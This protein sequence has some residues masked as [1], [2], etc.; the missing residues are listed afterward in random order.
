VRSDSPVTVVYAGRR[1][2]EPAATDG[3]VLLDDWG[4]LPRQLAEVLEGAGQLVILDPLSFPFESLPSRYWDIPMV[5]ELPADL[6]PGRL[7]ALL[8]SIA[9]SRLGF[10]DVLI[11][12][13]DRFGELARQY[14]LPQ[15]MR[16]D[17]DGSPGPATLAELIDQAV[18]HQMTLAQMRGRSA[19]RRDSW[20]L[21]TRAGKAEFNVEAGAVTDELGRIRGTLP[22]GTPGRAFVLGCGFG[23]WL[24]VARRAGLDVAGFDLDHVAVARSRFNYPDLPVC[25]IALPPATPD[26]IEAADVALIAG[27]LGSLD[28]DARLGA[29]TWAWSTLRPGGCLM[30]LEDCVGERGAA[31]WLPV[32][33]LNAAVVA[34]TANH[35]VLENARALRLEGE[36]FHRVGLVTY[37]KLGAAER[38]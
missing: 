15:A 36:S 12:A 11:N 14:H 13:G 33:D 23:E 20:G 4:V 18:L 10:H 27:V 34:V 1:P 25:H 37:A 32:A 5:V 26:L 6:N 31:H 21:R 19:R 35:A 22:A 8:G 16:L 17:I 29:L 28:G 30:V 2:I 7:T 9:F 24:M 38:L 3:V